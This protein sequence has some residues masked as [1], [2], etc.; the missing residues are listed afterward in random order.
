MSGTCCC[1]DQRDPLGQARCW[2]VSSADNCPVSVSCAY[3]ES[4]DTGVCT[5]ARISSDNLIT[6]FKDRPEMI[7]AMADT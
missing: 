7:M 3:R 2:S 1:I 4:I 5:A 6:P